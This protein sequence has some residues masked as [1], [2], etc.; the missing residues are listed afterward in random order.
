MR[1]SFPSISID[2]YQNNIKR[3]PCRLGYMARR[4]YAD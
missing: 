4:P 3:N 2:R 1:S